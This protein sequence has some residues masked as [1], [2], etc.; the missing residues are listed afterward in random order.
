MSPKAPFAP[1][2]GICRAQVASPD[3]LMIEPPMF[4]TP[5]KVPE[6]RL[7]TIDSV[8]CFQVASATPALDAARYVPVTKMSGPASRIPW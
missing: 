8:G 3:Q 4:W 1:V 6:I 5:E 2:P 7:T